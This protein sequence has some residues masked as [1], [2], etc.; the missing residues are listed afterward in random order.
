MEYIQDNYPAID[1]P[2]HELRPWKV[3]I[4]S[5]LEQPADR[6]KIIFIVDEIGNS[7]KLGLL[8]IIRQNWVMKRK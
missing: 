6:S 5:L 7:G 4:R 3:H 8:I 1:L 2:E